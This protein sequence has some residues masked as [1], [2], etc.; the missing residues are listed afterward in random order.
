MEIAKWFIY[1]YI[2]I[3]FNETRAAVRVSTIVTSNDYIERSDRWIFP[4]LEP[5]GPLWEELS[6]DINFIKI[7]RLDFKI[8]VNQILVKTAPT[9]PLTRNVVYIFR[10]I[11]NK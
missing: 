11:F 3:K 6:N 2:N 1:L 10:A 7:R 5:L 8:C 9:P 4:K